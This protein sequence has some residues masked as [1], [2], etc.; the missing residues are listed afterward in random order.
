MSATVGVALVDADGEIGM[1][2]SWDVESV[3]SLRMDAGDAA[4]AMAAEIAHD[5]VL[6]WPEAT[7]GAPYTPTGSW[8]SEE[9]A[10]R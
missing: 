4:R 10:L 1:R 2:L 7:P 9:L 5:M 6:V 3:I 8:E